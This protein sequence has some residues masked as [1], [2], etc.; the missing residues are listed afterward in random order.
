MNSDW[1][2]R[3]VSPDEAVAG[4]R[5]GMKVFVHGAAATPTP[6]LEALRARTDLE[7]VTLYHLHTDGPAPFAAPGAGRAFPLGLA[8]HRARR[9]AE[10]IAEGRADFVPIFLSDIPALFTSGQRAARRRA[11]CSSRRPTATASARS[12]RRSTPPAPRPT[13]APLIIAEINDADAAHARQHRRAVRPAR[14]VHRT[15]TG[16][17]TSTRRRRRPRSR[18]ASASSSRS[19]STTARRCRWASAPFPTRCCRRL[20]NKRDLGVHTE[21]FSDRVVD[22]VEAGVDHQP[23]QGGA[24][25]PHRHV[26]RQRHAAAVRLRGRQPAGRVPP[27]RPHERH[28]ASSGKNPKVVA[29]N[30]AL[31]GRPDG[32]GV[33]RLDR[34]PDLLG[35]RRP[36][37]LHP[38]R[39]AL[40]G[41]QADHRAAVDGGEGHGVAHRPGAQAR[42]PAW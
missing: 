27:V 17:C 12:A 8:L 41:R 19:S 3:A 13:S 28:R 36:D 22:L 21:M 16:R 9:C 24:P 32:P 29:I 30:S 31:R 25:G 5:S 2:S 1:S 4:I 42:A 37:G 11:C 20:G 18:R 7:D 39:G 6:L 34:P 15:P 14:R 33:R 38:R 23:L 40:A 26:V 35:H 10:P